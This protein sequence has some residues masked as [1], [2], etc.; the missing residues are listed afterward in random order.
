MLLLSQGGSLEHARD[1]APAEDHAAI[2]DL[3]QLWHV[4]RAHKDCVALRCEL[5]D[6]LVDLD[7]RA[8][9]HAARR[10]V[11]EQDARLAHQGPTQQYLL[12]VATAERRDQLTG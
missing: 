6:E 1:A 4:R 2:A 8:Y 7:L 10:L 9:V 12:L 11:Q 5:S 3:V